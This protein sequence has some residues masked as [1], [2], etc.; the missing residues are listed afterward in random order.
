M[1]ALAA[2]LGNNWNY[3]IQINRGKIR[4]FRYYT[5]GHVNSNYEYRNWTKAAATD[6]ISVEE[7]ETL[8]QDSWNKED[9]KLVRSAGQ[10]IEACFHT[11][12]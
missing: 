9:M 8:Q 6:V 10:H 4:L 11:G 7:L 5:N 2:H 1:E 12:I 3:G